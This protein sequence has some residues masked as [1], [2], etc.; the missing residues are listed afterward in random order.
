MKITPNEFSTFME[1]CHEKL[2]EACIDY[3]LSGVASIDEIEIGEKDTLFS[4][5]ERML[6]IANNYFQGKTKI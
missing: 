4:P 2:Y 5:T 1:E 3:I 6:L